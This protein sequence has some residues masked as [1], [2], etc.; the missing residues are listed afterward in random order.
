MKKLNK[1]QTLI[2]YRDYIITIELVGHTKAN[3]PKYKVSFT[4]GL[5]HGEYDKGY[6]TFYNIV[7]NDII[8]KCKEQVD[9]A[10]IGGTEL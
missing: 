10:I 2:V 5:L 6:A 8:E 9:Y 7:G 1:G 4:Y 3:E